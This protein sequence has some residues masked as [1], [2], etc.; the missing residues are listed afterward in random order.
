M[1]ILSSSLHGCSSRVLHLTH[2]NR[3]GDLSVDIT[4]P[5]SSSLLPISPSLSPLHLFFLL[6]WIEFVY[7]VGI[8]AEASWAFILMT[9]LSGRKLNSLSQLQYENSQKRLVMGPVSH[10]FTCRSEV[11]G[12]MIGPTWVQGGRG[13]TC[14]Q[15]NL[16]VGGHQ[17]K[18]LWIGSTTM[19]DLTKLFAVHYFLATST[20]F[21]NKA[22]HQYIYQ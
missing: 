19:G 17:E 11:W 13:C 15:K 12:T 1:S 4:R 3:K 16:G 22:G 6:L 7:M 5:G 9:L 18:S 20:P 10:L 8:L 21:W 14:Y 2:W